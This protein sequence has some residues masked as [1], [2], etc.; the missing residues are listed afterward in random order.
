MSEDEALAMRSYMLLLG[1]KECSAVC[2]VIVAVEQ[3]MRVP[4]SENVLQV[5][6][7]CCVGVS[8]MLR[9]SLFPPEP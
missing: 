5:L 4:K 9:M 1:N 7:T 3:P 2:I 8:E 6:I